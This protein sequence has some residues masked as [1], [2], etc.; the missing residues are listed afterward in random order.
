MSR[1]ILHMSKNVWLLNLIFFI[2][3]Y[4]LVDDDDAMNSNGY[5]NPGDELNISNKTIDEQVYKISDC[6]YDKINCFLT[7]F[8]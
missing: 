7:F 5:H 1:I 2:S 3:I 6:L 8:V 4:H